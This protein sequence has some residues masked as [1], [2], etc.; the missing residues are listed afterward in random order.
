MTVPADRVEIPKDAFLKRTG[1][2]WKL[3]VGG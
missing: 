3:V 1:Q 2:L